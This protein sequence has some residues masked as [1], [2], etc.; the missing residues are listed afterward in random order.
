MT[1]ST[2][3]SGPK[4]CLTCIAPGARADPSAGSVA[5]F[6]GLRAD[7]SSGAV[8][9]RGQA[10]DLSVREAT[11]LRALL[12]R[13]GHAVAKERLSDVVFV[14]E[15]SV[16]SDAIEVVVYRLRKKLVGTTTQLV[17]LRGLGYLLKAVS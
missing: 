3:P 9:H 4:R 14:G 6:C 2:S 16:Q 5:E 1:G 10:L 11:L 15:T 8:Y 13:P 17:T 7:A 12:A